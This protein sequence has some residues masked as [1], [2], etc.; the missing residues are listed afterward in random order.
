MHVQTISHEDEGSD[1]GDP[2]GSGNAKYCQQ[3]TR[4]KGSGVEQILPCSLHSE[5]TSPA[6]TLTSDIHSPEL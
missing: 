2:I 1:W 3:T 4:H 6:D 5:G